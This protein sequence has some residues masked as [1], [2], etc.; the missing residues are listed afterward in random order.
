MEQFDTYY[1]D[2]MAKK[3]SGHCTAA[4]INELEQ[5]L[6]ASP[7]HQAEYD[8]LSKI[9]QDSV[10][11]DSARTYNPDSAWQKVESATAPATPVRPMA[12]WKKFSAAAAVIAAVAAASWFFSHTPPKKH[13]LAAN[14]GKIKSIQLPD[15]S[16]VTLR[17]GARIKYINGY[18]HDKRV[19]ELEGE[20]F[21]EVAN[22][23]E[24]PFLVKTANESYIEVLGTSFTVQS[25][26][27]STAVIVATG[28]VRLGAE[29][30]TADVILNAGQRGVWGNG[31][32]SSRNNNNPNFIAW[33]TGVLAF[34]DQSLLEILPQLADFYAKEIRIDSNYQTTAAKQKATITFSN[35]SC[36]DA[37]HEL[38]L[39]L[40][41]NFR[42]EGDA[43]VISQ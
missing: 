21:F 6:A 1:Y 36:D 32:L 20:A 39:L 16:M 29:N 13:E 22:D 33:K 43:I 3:L 34:N 18:H 2:L 14:E 23:P 31:Q 19:V 41:F 37:L 7:E 24:H 10:P 8:I 9:W 11:A 38:Q 4:E 30:D 27:D 15:K 35:Q 25:T 5:W 42:H 28:Q 26:K 12:N 17:Q 40:G